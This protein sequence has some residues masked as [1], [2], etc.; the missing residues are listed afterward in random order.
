MAF[1]HYRT[2][3]IF[4]RKEGRGEADQLFSIFT[5]DFGK[6]EI[7]GRAI[8]KITSKLRAG[9]NLFYLSEIEFIQGKTYKTLTDAILIDKFKDLRGDPQRLEI[10]H[11]IAEPLNILLGK[12]ERDDKI[13]QLLLNAFK[14]L[15][16]SLPTT[17][18]SLIYHYFLWN[19]FSLLGFKPELH[20]CPVCRKKLLPETFW[21]LP[22]EGGI[23]C[24]R[25]LKKTKEDEKKGI[26][27]ISVDTV[28]ILRIFLSEDWKILP[29]I[30]ISEEAKRNLKEISELYLKFL[31]EEFSKME[32]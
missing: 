18:Y 10:A 7:L 24:W 31:G 2:Q 14:K 19:L 21:F 20:N 15:D 5:K 12:E 8:R 25:C 13:W 22:R 3:G 26:K 32:K 28:K 6:L 1:T 29:R 27:E 11:K 17:H 9:T 16:Y 30:K 4:L 23:V